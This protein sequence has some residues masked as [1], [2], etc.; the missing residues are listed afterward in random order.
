MRRFAEEGIQL[1]LPATRTYF[2]QQD[3]QE[4]KGLETG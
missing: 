1:A 2:S 3:G 4:V